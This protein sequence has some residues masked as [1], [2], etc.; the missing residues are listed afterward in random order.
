M[1]AVALR[2]GATLARWPAAGCW[3]LLLRLGSLGWWLALAFGKAFFG[4]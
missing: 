1:F 3:P 4:G 2:A